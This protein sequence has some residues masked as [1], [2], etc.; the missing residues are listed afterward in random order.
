MRPST[1]TIFVDNLPLHSVEDSDLE[2][3]RKLTS[4]FLWQLPERNLLPNLTAAENIQFA[5]EISNFSR[6]E[7]E[8]RIQEL[9]TKIGPG[10]GGIIPPQTLY[11]PWRLTFGF[12]G[13]MFVSTG[14]A[15]GFPALRVASKQT[16]NV[17]RAE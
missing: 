11:I 9:L 6:E 5:M 10:V 2:H 3:Y 16:G 13:T 4:G 15:A 1:G 17:L 12:L 7:R 8:K 14:I